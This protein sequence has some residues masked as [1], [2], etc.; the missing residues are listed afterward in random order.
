MADRIRCLGDDRAPRIDD[1]RAAEGRLAGRSAD[2]R[3]GED[4][5]G[6]LDRPRP[7]QD[8]PV[9][10]TS[11]LGEVGRDGQ[12]RRAGQRERAVEL[13]EAQV[14]ADRQA[15]GGA[16]D[17]GRDQP[18]AG[19]HPGRLGV[20]R[21]GLD[22]DVEQVD[23]AIPRGDR[24]VRARSAR[25]CCT[26]GPGRRSSRPCCRPGSR[27]RAGAPPRR[28][29]P[30]AGPGWAVPRRDSHRPGR[31]TG[32]TRGAPPAGRRRRP[33][34]RRGLPP[35]RCWPRRHRSH[36]AGRGRPTGASR[37]GTAPT[38]VRGSRCRS[39]S[40]PWRA[41]RRS[42]RRAAPVASP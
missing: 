36:R 28:T 17:V 40:R 37:H 32:G 7:E 41:R 18:V 27:R 34:R 24:S 5:R 29:G 6:V 3:R 16:V 14:V 26:G 1:H 25:T 21:A 20:D 9:V 38:A 15:D 35:W 11:A 23:L 42:R 8:L 22:R 19:R 30:C 33:P 31:G 39:R 4:V 13:R 2:L 12:D 10:A